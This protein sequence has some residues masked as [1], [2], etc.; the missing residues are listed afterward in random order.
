MYSKLTDEIPMNLTP[1]I[2]RPNTRL[3]QEQ[4]DFIAKTVVE[5]SEDVSVEDGYKLP[6]LNASTGELLFH[7]SNTYSELQTLAAKVLLREF[8]RKGFLTR[9]TLYAVTRESIDKDK[10]WD[11]PGELFAVEQHVLNRERNEFALA[12]SPAV[13]SPSIGGLESA[14]SKLGD[15]MITGLEGFQGMYGYLIMKISGTGQSVAKEERNLMHALNDPWRKSE[16]T[17][18]LDVLSPHARFDHDVYQSLGKLVS[19]EALYKIQHNNN[20]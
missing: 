15:A 12:S 9:L 10:V 19:K 11:E 16:A 2:E 1:Q 17:I 8:E 20:S 14:S 13:F 3:T 7:P 5:A 18:N 4:A 6:Y